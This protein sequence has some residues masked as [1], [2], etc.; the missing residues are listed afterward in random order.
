MGLSDTFLVRCMAEVES[1]YGTVP[2]WA[3]ADDGFYLCDNSNPVKLDTAKT[4]PKYLRD[5]YTQL[6]DTIGRQLYTLDPKTYVAGSG[7][8]GTPVRY[9]DLLRCS[10]LLET[11]ASSSVVY[12]PASSAL[13]T[14]SVAIELDGVEYVAPGCYGSFVISG[15]A[16]QPADIQFS[17][18]GNYQKPIT[19]TSFSGW[20]GGSNN[21]P[22]IKSAN[23]TINN[24][25][26]TWTTLTANVPLIVKN[27]KFDRGLDIGEIT[28][29]NSPTALYGLAI[30]AAKPS[31]EI[32]VQAHDTMAGIPDFWAN[33]TDQVAHAISWQVG[34]TAG[35][36]WQFSFPKAQLVDA[37]PADGEAGT[38]NYTL[39][40][41]IQHDTPDTEFS[42]ITK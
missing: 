36:I 33:L 14:A 3:P 6:Q 16:G 22:S 11:V 1:V 21:A 18:K 28:D 19:A 35:N 10:A 38:R 15:S 25:S 8:A 12:T 9:N 24:G 2:T 37:T 41:K 31:L 40:Y 23:V 29:C 17:L 32:T 34:Q 42:I 20:A 27:F 13:K 4:E 39:M 26:I 5:T 7:A 30:A